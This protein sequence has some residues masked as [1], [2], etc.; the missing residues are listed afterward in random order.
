MR[1]SPSIKS[2][3]AFTLLLLALICH[4]SRAVVCSSNTDCESCLYF[5][6]QC[7]WCANT[8]L[9]INSGPS[10]CTDPRALQANCPNNATSLSQTAL[11]G[12]IAGV[13]AFVIFSIIIAICCFRR[14]CRNQS[15][16]RINESS[17]R[18]DSSGPEYGEENRHHDHTR[19][20]QYPQQNNHNFNNNNYNQY[21]TEQQ[22]QLQ[23]FQQQ[24]GQ[25]SSQQV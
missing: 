25:Y 10:T 24:K 11:I 15:N 21:I 9:C 2:I 7:V 6:E 20:Q 8:S 5:E 19:A 13:A 1:K 3:G 18:T 12:I 23:Q 22:R 16:R 17:V 4:S 14:Y